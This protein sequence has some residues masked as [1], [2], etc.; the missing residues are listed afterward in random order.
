MEVCWT[1][2]PVNSN[3][4]LR[5]FNLSAHFDKD[6]WIAVKTHLVQKAAYRVVRPVFLR[7]VRML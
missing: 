7:K 6:E 3:A 4:R 5:K 1:A 2:C